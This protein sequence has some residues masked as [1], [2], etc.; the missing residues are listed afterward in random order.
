MDPI[1]PTYGR[2]GYDLLDPM[3]VWYAR[4]LAAGGAAAPAVSADGV[5][6]L[7]LELPLQD[8]A[9]LYTLVQET[10]AVPE[11]RPRIDLYA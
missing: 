8:S 1:S 11:H 5:P 10:Q 2:S 3:E 4:R 7:Q 9:S 6:A